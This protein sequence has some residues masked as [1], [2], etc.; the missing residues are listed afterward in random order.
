MGVLAD[1]DVTQIVQMVVGV[2]TL[3][4]TTAGAGWSLYIG[5]RQKKIEADLELARIAAETAKAEAAKQGR[6]L[7]R[8][9]RKLTEETEKQTE[10]ITKLEKNTNGMQAQI[11]AE[12]RERALRE[13]HAQGTAAVEALAK[14]VASMT[15]KPVTIVNPEPI[16]VHESGENPKGDA[17][18]E[19]LEKFK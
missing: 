2:A 4:V 14:Q 18:A 6:R 12:A 7:N 3:L 8:K 19:H 15:P 11:L 9:A 1:V 16:P 10:I 17:P 13:G 5:F